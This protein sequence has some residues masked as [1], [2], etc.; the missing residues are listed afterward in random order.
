MR[1][2]RLGNKLGG[3]ETR[4][5]NRGTGKPSADM[6]RGP[7][8]LIAVVVLAAVLIVIWVVSAQV[9]TGREAPVSETVPQTTAPRTAPLDEGT[10]P[11]DPPP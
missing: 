8:V 2:W 7:A 5:E 4:E 11:L 3:M 6:R 1:A 10:G 9:R